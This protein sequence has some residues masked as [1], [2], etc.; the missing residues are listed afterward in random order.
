MKE[1]HQRVSRYH[2]RLSQGLC[3]EC[4]G[5]RDLDGIQCSN[6]RIAFNLS[7]SKISKA[8]KTEYQNNYLKRNRKA[9]LCPKCGGRRDEP[10]LIYCSKCRAAARARYYR[11]GG[12]AFVYLNDWSKHRMPQPL[13]PVCNQQ[14]QNCEDCGKMMHAIHGPE[15]CIWTCKCGNQRE[16]K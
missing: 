1:S 10:Q 6:C 13:C 5:P 15:S 8:Q 2:F 14:H 7:Q 3:P 16:I 12:K 9:G 4:G 11:K